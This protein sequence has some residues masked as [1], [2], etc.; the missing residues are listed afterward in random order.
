MT[1]ILIIINFLMI[2]IFF[3]NLNYIPPE[4]PL[5]YSKP[6]NT[7]QIT[8]FWMI[9]IIPILLN[10]F[11]FLNNYVLKKI[12]NNEKIIKKIIYYLNLFILISFFFIFVRIIFIIT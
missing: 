7:G 2:G 8:E 6:E 12:F 5:F 11:F 10:L 9:L 1:I 4:I 3:V